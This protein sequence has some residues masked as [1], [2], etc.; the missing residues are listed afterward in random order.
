MLVSSFANNLVLRYD[1]SDGRFVDLLPTSPLLNGPNALHYAKDG[2]L[3]LTTEGSMWERGN[4][5]FPFK[6]QILRLQNNAWEIF[7]DDATRFAKPN[8]VMSPNFL[9]LASSPIE[10]S[11]LWATDFSNGIL[12]FDLKS[13]E[14]IRRIETSYT[15][16][17]SANAIGSLSFQV[18]GENDM[19]TIYVPGFEPLRDNI[20]CILKF[21]FNA[22]FEIPKDGRAT[23]AVA[24][25]P[26]LQKPISIISFPPII[27]KP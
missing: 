18:T 12:A 10:D 26:R 1:A 27:S 14:L 24:P 25:T 2:I 15:G 5:S 8:Q 19:Y 3:Y 4:L 23:F 11:I 22:S 21:H 9:G 6:S 7:V 13:G 20:G 16:T 17:P